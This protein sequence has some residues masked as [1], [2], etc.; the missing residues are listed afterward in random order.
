[1]K[2]LVIALSLI[3][4]AYLASCKASKKSTPSHGKAKNHIELKA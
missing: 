3:S 1:M 2:N 4:V